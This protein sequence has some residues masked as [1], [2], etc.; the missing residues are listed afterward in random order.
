[1][2]T[3]ANEAPAAPAERGARRPH[4]GRPTRAEASRRQRH[5]LEVA[6]AMFMRDGFDGTSIDAVAEA[7]GTSKRTLYAR[8]ADKGELFGAVLRDLIERCLVPITRF[9]S[10]NVALEPTLVEIGRHLLASVLAPEAVSLHRII[11]AESERQPAFGRLAHAEGRK[12]AVKAIAALLRRHRDELRVADFEL[13]AQQ[14]LSLVVDN[15]LCLATLGIRDD[16]RGI[17][18]RVRA[19]V[20]L[21]LGGAARS[22][23]RSGLRTCSRPRG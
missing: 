8:Y 14:F 10:S 11:I 9:Q 1:M 2:R 12:P 18:A 13:A 19:A 23:H 20:D 6:G 21:F 4:G 16:R 7:A 17:D 15:S 5:L 3:V 22:A